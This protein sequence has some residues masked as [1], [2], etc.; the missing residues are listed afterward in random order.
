MTFAPG[1][2]LRPGNCV[3]ETGVLAPPEIQHVLLGEEREEGGRRA[4]LVHED[5]RAHGYDRQLVAALA[6]LPVV[7]VHGLHGYVKIEGAQGA[8]RVLV[9]GELGGLGKVEHQACAMAGD[10]LMLGCCRLAPAGPYKG[11]APA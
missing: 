7:V 6:P 3:L 9:F 4:A 11:P 5:A 8:W 2:F 1:F 10:S